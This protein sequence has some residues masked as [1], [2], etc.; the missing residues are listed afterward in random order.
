MKTYETLTMK[1]A[2][3]LSAPRSWVASILPAF[4]GIFFCKLYN[5]NLSISQS[6]LLVLACI[7]MQSSVNTLND[8]ADFIKGNRIMR[9]LT[10]F[11]Y[12]DIHSHILYEG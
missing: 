6:I 5:L 4:F 3:N 2:F 12:V 9:K 7:L 8:Y 11:H 10:T 1:M